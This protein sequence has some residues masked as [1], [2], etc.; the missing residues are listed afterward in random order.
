MMMLSSCLRGGLSPIGDRLS[1]QEEDHARDPA[2]INARYRCDLRSY[3]RGS[4]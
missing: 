3:C 2:T 1:E 4:R